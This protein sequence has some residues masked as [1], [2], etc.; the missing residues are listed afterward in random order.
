M[1]ESVVS[2]TLQVSR[3]N[4][5]TRQSV[6]VAILVPVYK[7]W[8]TRLGLGLSLTLS[9]GL[10][11]GGE[12]TDIVLRTILRHILCRFTKVVSGDLNSVVNYDA[13]PW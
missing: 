8:T 10:S 5:W 7:A 12:F 11:P 9:R 4:N 13:L 6:S 1:L 3:P 2:V